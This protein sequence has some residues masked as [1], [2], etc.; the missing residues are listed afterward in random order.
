ML[1]PVAAQDNGDD[2]GDDNGAE[3]PDR[4]DFELETLGMGPDEVG[5]PMGLAVLPDGRVLHTSRADGPHDPRI[6][7]DN[8]INGAGHVFLTDPEAGESTMI[9]EI[10]V[11]RFSEYGVQGIALDPDY[12]E[13]GWIYLYYTPADEDSP[14]VE[15]APR[16]GDPEDFEE[17]EGLAVL[18]RFQLDEE[19]DTPELDLD[20]EQVI[21]EVPQNFGLCCH[22][23]GDIDFDSEG[24]LYL[25][26]GDDTHFDAS[27]NYSPH[28]D[29]ETRNPGFDARRTSGNTNHLGG[30][31]LRIQPLDEPGDEPGLGSTYEVP[32]DNMFN[33][34]EW[35]DLFP[36]GEY[37]AELAAPEIYVMGVRNPFRFAID[38]VDDAIYLGDYGPDADQPDP[39]RGPENTVSWHVITEPVNIGWPYCIGN[40]AAYHEYDWETEESGEPFDC[41]GGPVNESRHN[42]GLEQLPPVTP[43]LIWYH[44]EETP[45]FPE[46]GTGGGAPMGGPAY[47]YEADVA[48]ESDVAWPEYFDGIPLLYEYSRNWIMEI[49][50]DDDNELDEIIE[51]MPE[52]D[53]NQPMDMEFGPDGALYLVEYGGGFFD[54]ADEASVSRIVYDESDDT[55][56]PPVSD[57]QCMALVTDEFDGDELDTDLW[58][59]IV[60]EN[61]DGYYVDDGALHIDT[62]DD[63]DMYGGNTDAENLILTPA[64]DGEWQITTEVEL[65]LDSEREYEQA[66]LLVYGDDENFVKLSF[67]QTPD[68]RDME[69]ILQEDGEPSNDGAVDR[70]ELLPDDY[71]DTVQVRITSD[72]ETVTASWSE[73]GA[74]FTEFGRERSLDA[75]DDPQI[76]VAAFNGA[77]DG[78]EAA[79]D[80][81]TIGGQVADPG[82]QSIQDGYTQL[83]DG[84]SLDGWNMA[85]PGEFLIVEDADREGTCALETHY[86]MGLLWHE[87]EFERYRFQAD[88]KAEAEDDNSGVFFGFPDPGDDPWIAVDEGYEINIDDTG[89]FDEAGPEHMTG[90]IY[91]FQGPTSF[92]TVAGEWNTMEIEV[93][94]PMVRVWINDELVN[95]YEDPGDLGRDLSSG[96]IGLQNN[97]LQDKV[98]FRDIQIIDL[99]D[100]DPGEPGEDTVCDR[101]QGGA[102]FPDVPNSGHGYFIDCLAELGVVVGYDDGNFGPGDNVKRGQLA[103]FVVRALETAGHDLEGG[104]VDFPDVGENSTHGE[105]IGKLA[106]AGV[107]QGYTDGTFGPDDSVSREQTATYVAGALEL[108][109]GELDDSDAGFPDVGSGGTHAQAID[110]LAT[111]EVIQGF[112]DGTFG[113]REPV[114]R[115]QMTRFI[116]NALEVLAEEGQYFGP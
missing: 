4:E 61:A 92:P 5:E 112:E 107:V 37:D 78:N 25:S 110:K 81:V 83:W 40:N 69:F 11:Y 73:D 113:P 29:R 55:D 106:N 97:R 10:P 91:T 109:I 14:E 32:D 82:E 9:A 76:G 51:A 34:G 89:G 100:D 116:G 75:I 68:G 79:F 26:T 104:E 36:D 63:T 33:S 13:N 44:Y 28:D 27:D 66:G 77:G 87:E 98:Q 38:P 60:R 111:A 88:F 71:G 22:V 56:P 108:I 103:S 64:P 16:D 74:E 96:Y 23:G 2:N 12:E 41:E 6:D 45:E 35:D 42:T 105:A 90:S 115:G 95:E 52:V 70:S 7:H 47:E 93:D 24:N 72:G 84:E 43:A 50:L 86:G 18:S 99:E 3:A 15:E 53:L 59:N 94:D 46:L 54:A 114:T 85:G 58:S 80:H 65:E 20:S 48:A 67:I 1:G 31:I 17:Y 30:S 39:D 8:P 21:L 57:A 49:H 101:H 19:D 62:G 102:T